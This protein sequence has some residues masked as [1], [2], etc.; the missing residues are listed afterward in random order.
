LSLIG[1][2]SYVKRYQLLFVS[3][4]LL[5]TTGIKAQQPLFRALSP[6][7]SG[8]DFSNVVLESRDRNIGKYDY[9]YNGGGVAVGD[10]NNDGLPDIFFTGN[11]VNDALYLNRGK[12]HFEKATNAGILPGGWS[13]GATMVDINNDGWLDIYVC[14]S[15]PDYQENNTPNLLYINNRNGT[16]SEQAA[17]YGIAGN[18]LSTQAVFYDMDLD[19][20][21]DLLVLNHGVRNL[22]NTARDWMQ[23]V[24]NLPE[25]TYRRFSNT[26]YK[27]ENGSYVDISREAGVLQAGFGLGVAIA[28]FDRNALPDVFVANDF[29]LPDQILMLNN[30]GAYSDLINLKFPHVTFSS[31]GCDAAD[32]NN[33]GWIDLAVLDMRPSTHEG[34][35]TMHMDMPESDMLFLER[36]MQF[37][38]QEM[39]NAI[40]INNGLGV[41]TDIAQMLGADATD[42][43]W[44]VLLADLD[45]D[46]WKDMFITNGYYRET[47]DSDWRL[48]LIRYIKEGNLNDSLYFE[49]LM[50]APRMPVH[51]FVYKNIDGYAWEDKTSEWGMDAPGYTHGAAYADLDLDGDLDII[52]NSLDAP[53]GLFE[54][55]AGN[56][57]RYLRL[58]DTS[59]RLLCAEL[60]AE[61]T[62]QMVASGVTRGYQSS[63]EPVLHFG[64]GALTPDSVVLTWTTGIATTIQKPPFNEVLTVGPEGNKPSEYIYEGENLL[65][66]NE[67]ARLIQPPFYHTAAKSQDPVAYPN[68]P[69]SQSHEGPALAV[70]DVNGDGLEDFFIGGTAQQPGDLYVQGAANLFTVVQQSIWN[71]GGKMETV[72]AA[73]F[74]ADGDG[75]MDLYLGNG[76]GA[77]F[78]KS[79]EQLQ[80]IL[81]L[82]NG[83]GVFEK[84]DLPQM[85]NSTGVVLPLDFDADGDMDLFIGGRTV[86]GKYPAI[87]RS[88]LLEN[89][90][91]KF[92]DITADYALLT[93]PGMITDALWTDWDGADGK[94][95]VLV[96]E[97]MAPR[98]FQ[99]NR[100]GIK[101]IS[102][103]D[104]AELKGMWNCII[105]LDADGDGDED[106][107][108]GNIGKNSIWHPDMQNPVYLYANKD[109]A[110]QL[111]TATTHN[112]AILPGLSREPMLRLLRLPV[113]TYADNHTYAGAT[114]PE[115][116][117]K[118]GW[119]DYT[120]LQINTVEHLWLINEGR[121]NYSIEAAP[122]EVQL[123]AVYDAVVN[124]FNGDGL[125][126]MVLAGNNTHMDMHLGL[127][128]AGTGLFLAGKLGQ[129]PQPNMLSVKTGVFLPN[130]V[131]SMTMITLAEGNKKAFLVGKNNSRLNILVWN[132]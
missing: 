98:V 46:G 28:D 6:A 101:E 119:E 31:M 114:V 115:L 131:R 128:D 49:H 113:E 73:F 93:Y 97:W 92:T 116:L 111:F 38:P 91:G 37:L 104:I 14:R 75:D 36:E 9:F 34:H 52:T 94:E 51:N 89:K 126:D 4:L 68:I 108:L 70:G 64:F 81:L 100:K 61:G 109:N 90:N 47:M 62:Y 72:D 33:D 102:A 132:R 87:P 12:L 48:Q 103:K 45:N 16:F 32:I 110:Q 130:D 74:D 95:L 17:K 80:D 41:M 27:N 10:I 22:A 69:L 78:G 58:V 42:W 125:A 88:Y 121:G 82:N 65:F 1:Y 18:E 76:G 25:E 39:H 112:G 8:L 83:L 55:T 120:R 127:L 96:G 118:A 40:Y 59:G 107:F 124:D 54:N 56:K 26:L 123:S 84:A 29:F 129:L 71:D 86:P 60:Y 15:G 5:A 53:A 50:R 122:D 24:R 13:T 19:G 63:V 67:T 99:F 66:L 21:L 2:L 23:T 3:F 57:G 11:D 105:P 43:S 79:P 117:G 77:A 106:Y 20:D 85:W 35:M 44:S 7:V 30:Q